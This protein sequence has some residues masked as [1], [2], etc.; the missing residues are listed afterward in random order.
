M[1]ETNFFKGCSPIEEANVEGEDVHCRQW[2]FLA[3]VWE[4]VLSLPAGKE[5]HSTY[6][7][8]LQDPKCEW[9]RSFHSRCE[10]L[11]PGAQHLIVRARGGRWAFR[12]V[13]CAILRRIGVFLS[14]ATRRTLHADT[15][16]KDHHVL[17]RHFRS[18][19][20]GHSADGYSIYQARLLPE[21]TLCQI[22]KRR[23]QF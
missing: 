6:Q 8:L 17:Y 3:H 4:K 12:I 19:G 20:C 22:W 23:K 16:Q 9:N 18:S 13:S 2:S 14:W 5:K 10:G 7:K 15:R 21:E 1:H 11:H